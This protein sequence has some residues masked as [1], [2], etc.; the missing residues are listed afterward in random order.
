MRYKILFL[1]LVFSLF[2][3]GVVLKRTG[4]NLIAVCQ[5]VNRTEIDMTGI[6]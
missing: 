3:N 5:D 2:A 1:F 6:E 4:W